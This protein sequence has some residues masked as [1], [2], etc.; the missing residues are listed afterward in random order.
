MQLASPNGIE[1]AIDHAL[2]P[3]LVYFRHDHRKFSPSSSP[4]PSSSSSSSSSPSSSFSSSSSSSSSLLPLLLATSPSHPF[5]GRIFLL[6]F[7][8]PSSITLKLIML[9]V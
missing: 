8:H 7:R 6:H 4:S 1:R 2:S 5:F 3:T 9:P